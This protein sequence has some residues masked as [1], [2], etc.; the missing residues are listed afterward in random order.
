V[1]CHTQGGRVK[2][3]VKKNVKKLILDKETLARLSVTG[4]LYVEN[5][6]DSSGPEICWFS[7]C[8]AC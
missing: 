1:R 8:N 5:Q 2:K 4:G 7:D 6:V 3:L